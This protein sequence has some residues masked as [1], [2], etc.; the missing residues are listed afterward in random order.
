MTD[1]LENAI[2]SAGLSPCIA[3]AAVRTL[4]LTATFMPMNPAV[5]EQIVPT[6]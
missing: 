2:R 5:A 4:A 1:P 6:K 3:A